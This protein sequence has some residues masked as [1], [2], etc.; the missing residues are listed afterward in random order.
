MNTSKATRQARDTKIIAA[1]AAH[2]TGATTITLGGVDHKV[3]DIQVLLQS[4]IDAASATQVAKAKWQTAAATEQEKTTEVD[5]VLI[6]LKSHLVTTYGAKS[7]I[8]TDFGFTP[9]AK[10]V[11]AETAATAVVKRAAT[12][13]ARGTMGKKQKEKIKGVVTPATSAPAPVTAPV[14]GGTPPP[15]TGSH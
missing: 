12:R 3:K 9:K 13:L 4:R 10:K 8:V 15:T 14:T 2:F 5:G 6:A 7:E 1:L 11:T